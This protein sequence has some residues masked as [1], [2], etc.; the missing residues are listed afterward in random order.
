MRFS[1]KWF[2][3]RSEVA[4]EKKEMRHARANK[5]ASEVRC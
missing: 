3:P 5:I 2:L 1:K 4:P